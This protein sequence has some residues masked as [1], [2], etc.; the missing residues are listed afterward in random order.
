LHNISFEDILLNFV[1]VGLLFVA[2]F[3]QAM[4]KYESATA[5]S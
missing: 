1:C 3:A 4:Q 2:L 5:R